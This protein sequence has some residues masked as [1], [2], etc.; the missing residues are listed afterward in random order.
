MFTGLTSF[1]EAHRVVLLAAGFSIGSALLSLLK[2]SLTF[3]RGSATITAVKNADG[4]ATVSIETP[5]AG[6][7]VTGHLGAKPGVSAATVTVEGTKISL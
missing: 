4:S 7:E 3:K 6:V 2:G 5:I 1:L